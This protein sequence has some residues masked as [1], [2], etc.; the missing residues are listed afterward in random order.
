V[1]KPSVRELGRGRQL[2][3]L[4]F[5]D[6]EGLVASYLI[7]E[8]DGWMVVETGPTTCRDLLLRGI[9]LAGVERTA[10]RHVLVTHIHLDHA[11]GAG[12]LLDD[13]PNAEF[14]A[15]RLGLPH[16]L[17]PTRLVASA[18]RVWGA[19]AD[20]LWGPIIPVTPNRIQPLVGGEQFA[21]QGGALEVLN[22]PGHAKHHLAFFD[23]PTRAIL[24]GD[25][26]GVRIERAPRP[27]PAI[28]PPDLDLEELYRSIDAM[29]QK[30]PGAVWYSHFGPAPNGADDL[31]I[32]PGI[33]EEWKQIAWKASQES[34]DPKFVAQRLREYEESRAAAEESTRMAENREDLVSGYEIAAMGLLHYFEKKGRMGRG[35]G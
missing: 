17:D 3:D 32:Y 25:G 16:L 11:G 1:V 29:R 22:T 4:G 13:L 33:C 2:I 6:T 19:A 9:E 20:P 15:H 28:P 35:A 14:F 23:A 34:S 21:V 10:V 12:A 18:R 5:R 31:A 24:T 7:P 27:R 30:N 8:D 26:A